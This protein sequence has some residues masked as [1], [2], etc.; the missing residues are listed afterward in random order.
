M[1]IPAGCLHSIEDGVMHSDRGRRTI[2]GLVK[3]LKNLE[4]I[5]LGEA[6]WCHTGRLHFCSLCDCNTKMHQTQRRRQGKGEQK[7][8]ESEKSRPEQ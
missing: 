8:T 6:G 3:Q 5:H 2:V 7:S 4:I 1:R